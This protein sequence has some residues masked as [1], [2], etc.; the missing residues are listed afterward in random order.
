MMVYKEACAAFIDFEEGNADDADANA[1]DVEKCRVEMISAI[2]SYEESIAYHGF[3]RLFPPAE[4]QNLQ[5]ELLHL[6]QVEFYAR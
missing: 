4:Y 1:Q 3:R 5:E 6:K 2:R